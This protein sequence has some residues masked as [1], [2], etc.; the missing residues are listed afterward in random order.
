MVTQ[1][2]T[3]L[4]FSP[5]SWAP[6]GRATGTRPCTE[7]HR[8]AGRARRSAHGP[9]SYLPSARS[10][11]RARLTGTSPFCGEEADHTLSRAG[12]ATLPSNPTARQHSASISCKAVPSLHSRGLQPPSSPTEGATHSTSHAGAASGIKTPGTTSMTLPGAGQG[13]P[14]LSTSLIPSVACRH[15]CT[16]A[17]LPTHLH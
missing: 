11:C 2:I 1:N 13:K 14:H 6:L 8:G 9:G 15:I 4:F 17:G 5:V 12:Q 3:A 7:R 10:A 16:A